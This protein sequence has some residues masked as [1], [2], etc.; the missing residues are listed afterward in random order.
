M[1]PEQHTDALQEGAISAFLHLRSQ[2]IPT[3]TIAFLDEH[4]LASR[5]REVNEL[6]KLLDSPKLASPYKVLFKSNPSRLEHSFHCGARTGR[7][8][9]QA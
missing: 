4:N 6:Q 5:S 2:G 8:R 7:F 9:A 1:T 3:V